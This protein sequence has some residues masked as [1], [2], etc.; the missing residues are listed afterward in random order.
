MN[1]TQLAL[2]RYLW[3]E[4]DQRLRRHGQGTTS[5]ELRDFS[6]HYWYQQSRDYLWSS[7]CS[8]PAICS[9][10]DSLVA[11]G[12][13]NNT[14]SLVQLETGETAVVLDGHN[15]ALISLAFSHD[16]RTLASASEDGCIRLWDVNTGKV[17]HHLQNAGEA[18]R[19]VAFSEHDE[20]IV[21]SSDTHFTAWLVDSGELHSTVEVKDRNG[22]FVTPNVVA[23]SPFAEYVAFRASEMLH[24]WKRDTGELLWTTPLGGGAMV[25]SMDAKLLYTVIHGSTV[26]AYDVGNGASHAVGRD[27]ATP[28]AI[29]LSKD[30]NRMATGWA[31]GVVRLWDVAR[32]RAIATF[33]GQ[34]EEICSLSFSCDGTKLVSVSTSND[35]RTW[36]L[37]NLPASEPCTPMQERGVDRLV[38]S[39]SDN[40][41]AGATGNEVWMRKCDALAEKTVLGV[42]KAGVNRLVFSGTGRL[43]ASHSLNG[44]AVIW[45]VASK[46]QLCNLDISRHWLT[47]FRFSPDERLFAAPSADDSGAGVWNA[48]T[49]EI[50]ATVTDPGVVGA[51]F[52]HDGRTLILTASHYGSRDALS[53]YDVDDWTLRARILD[54]QPGAYVVCDAELADDGCTLIT[55]NGNGTIC[56]W[57]LEKRCVKKRLRGTTGRGT[58]IAVSPDGKSLASAEFDGLGLWNLECGESVSHWRIRTGT[59]APTASFS[60][61]GKIL[62]ATGNGTAYWWRC[63]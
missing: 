33:I 35:I 14:I 34:S 46:E 59:V 36:D 15:S 48:R 9:T 31:E 6:W 52:S 45:D 24:M 27:Q 17:V 18:A 5:S 51:L 8:G 57:D 43:L 10:T 42:H 61:D 25:F 22:S 20:L 49:G 19:A 23:I 26:T 58:W 44:E 37:T 41:Q 39:P 2:T 54:D 32:A 62:V 4:A 63:D 7:K 13:P 12:K 55:G 38:F 40:L 53:L 3:A 11:I 21:A 60:A 28:C 50:V 56:F 47:N 1:L 30:G 16:G 29:G